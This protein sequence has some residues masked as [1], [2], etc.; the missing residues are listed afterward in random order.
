[1]EILRT[2]DARFEKL[3]DYDF[4]PSY[5]VVRDAGGAEIRIHHVDVG[6]KDAQPIRV[7]RI[8]PG[9]DPQRSGL[10]DDALVFGGVQDPQVLAHAQL[11]G[12]DAAI[13]IRAEGDGI[14]GGGTVT[15]ADLPGIHG[16]IAKVL[17]SD[18]PVLVP[19]QA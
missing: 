9:A 19:D 10:L 17:V 1:M 8:D 15:G 18:I 5:T 16:V 4:A 14:Q 11:H 7:D 3:P 12:G 6:P 13:S 2:P